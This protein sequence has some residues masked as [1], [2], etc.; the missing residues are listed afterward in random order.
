MQSYRSQAFFSHKFGDERVSPT[1]ELIEKI[2]SALDITC[3]NVSHGHPDVP[4]GVAREKIEEADFLIALCSREKKIEDDDLWTFSDAVQ[5][6]LTIAYTLK[7]PVI[8]F[9]EK[10]VRLAGFSGN[11][12]TYQDIDLGLE[13]SDIVEIITKSIHQCKVKSIRDDGAFTSHNFLDYYLRKSVMQVELDPVGNDYTWNYIIEKTINFENHTAEPIAGGAWSLVP[14][15]DDCAPPNASAHLIDSSREFKLEVEKEAIGRNG[16]EIEMNL[17]PAPNKDDW[18]KIGERYS[19]PHLNK[20]W[21]DSVVYGGI[22]FNGKRLNAYDGC[23]VA[24]RI[25]ELEVRIIFPP[26]YK[27]QDLTHIVSTF[28]NK[29][30]RLNQ[31]EIERI[32]RESCVSISE[33]NGKKTAQLNIVRPLFQYFY[34]FAWNPPSI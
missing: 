26:G 22:N 5:Q 28:S 19:S 13:L 17:I 34:G 29:L 31:S 2:C 3:S 21:M 9:K 18:V 20:I 8:C 12:F 10:G 24:N 32:E 16:T 1:I 23:C 14:E 25:E 7:K 11:M 33:F 27:V 4:G 15:G 6:E 30:D